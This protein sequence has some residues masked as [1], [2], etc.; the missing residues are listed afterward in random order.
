M[1]RRSSFRKFL[2]LTEALLI[3]ACGGLYLL[4]FILGNG[5]GVIDKL[6]FGIL[7]I[8]LFSQVPLLLFY[9][10]SSRRTALSNLSVSL[11][12]LFVLFLLAEIGFRY[13]S[14]TYIE[15][16]TIKEGPYYYKTHDPV[17]FKTNHPNCSFQKTLP[18][19]DGGATI[20]VRIN[21]QGVRGPEIAAKKADQKRVLLIG[22]SY[23]QA[24]QV[25]Y[26]Q[27]IGERIKSNLSDSTSII[28]HG[29]PSYSP[30]LEFNWLL[31]KGIHF[32]PDQVLLF[33]YMNDFYSS[34]QVGDAGY[35]P[36][37]KFDKNGYPSGFTFDDKPASEK[38]SPYTIL[39]QDLQRSALI[40]SLQSQLKAR[41][42]RT[43]FPTDQ[44]DNLLLL[45]KKE[46][47]LQYQKVEQANDPVQLF[48]WDLIAGLR[49]T[50]LWDEKLIKRIDKSISVL[51]NMKGFLDKENV[52]FGLVFIPF[53]WQLKD[54]GLQ[55]KD[56]VGL[57]DIVFPY[58]GLQAKFQQFCQSEKIP[59]LDLYSDFIDHK[60][61]WPD[62][63]LYYPYDQHWT[64][65]GHQLAAD[66]VVDFFLLSA[67]NEE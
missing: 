13:F 19:I 61:R 62:R 11:F 56:L 58:S 57:N 67:K 45:P 20:S 60:N 10:M 42:T 50:N 30:L 38:R 34:H 2:Y 43:A 15:D 27:T 18:P 31:H 14:T 32:K 26:E 17:F 41:H 9:G 39:L 44:F 66:K 5:D 47:T 55:S 37:T 64:A 36:Y 48:N 28:Q 24:V 25:P 52:S 3:L 33:I 12:S 22:D 54:E 1:D 21:S 29:F 23:I 6:G 49:D 59:F 63:H 53:V 16:I 35:W 8:F 46:F 7:S 51:K 40:S 65:A 4:D